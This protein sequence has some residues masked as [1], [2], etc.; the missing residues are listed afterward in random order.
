MA[1][2]K[3]RSISTI[4]KAIKLT[5]LLTPIGALDAVAIKAPESKYGIFWWF[6][7]PILFNNITKIGVV[8]KILP[9]LLK[10]NVIKKLSK[11]TYQNNLIPD[12]LASSANFS[13]TQWKK[14]K[15]SKTIAITIV[16]KIVIAASVTVPAITPKSWNDTLPIRIITSA[17]IVAGIASFIPFGRHKIKPNEVKKVKFVSKTMDS[18]FNFNSFQTK[19]IMKKDFPFEFEI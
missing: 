12:P 16:A 10:N 2:C 1:V 5:I 6:F 9:S 7:N 14:P 15:L 19:P 17:P 4:F 13:A 8:I 3:Y 18:I 11:L